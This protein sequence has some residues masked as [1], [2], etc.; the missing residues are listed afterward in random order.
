MSPYILYPIVCVVYLLAGIVDGV[1][2]GGGL[3]SIPALLVLQI[4]AHLASGT[5]ICGAAIGSVTASAR[6]TREKKV[7]WPF[8]I[9]AGPTAGV[10]AALG[11]KLN[12]FVP[13]RYLQVVMTA[14]LPFIAIIILG[15][16]DFGKEN[17]VNELSLVRQRI[18]AAVIGLVVGTYNGFY[19]AGAGSFYLLAFAAFGKLDMVN[20]SG[21]AKICGLFAT[22]FA[23]VT[24]AL[25]GQVIWTM[26]LVS[27]VFNVAGNY[28]GAGIAIKKGSAM[29]RPVLIGVL[30]LLFIRLLYTIFF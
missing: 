29:I 17:H 11:A 30:V 14:L 13:E 27:T 10:G 6:F 18:L 24:Y 25:S 15:K 8:A 19:G 5:N 26:V 1:S 12:L 23:A 4:P 21:T 9:I 20:A 2:G 3:I 16:R 7:Y 28:F 22:F